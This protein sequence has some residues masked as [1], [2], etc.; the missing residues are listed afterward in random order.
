M[1]L[2]IGLVLGLFDNMMN[3]I[4]SIW[5]LLVCAA[6][7]SDNSHT[8][9]ICSVFLRNLTN[10]LCKHSCK[11]QWSSRGYT[12]YSCVKGLLSTCVVFCTLV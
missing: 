7:F 9:F 12:F 2:V 3:M 4:E 11:H 1:K 5:L 8:C 6:L 10:I